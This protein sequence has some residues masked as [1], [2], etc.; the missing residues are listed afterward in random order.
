MKLKDFCSL[1]VSYEKLRQH[2]KKHRYLTLL[3]KVHVVKVLVFPVVMYRCK[4]WTIKK[5]ECWRIHAFKLWCWRRLLRVPWTARRSNQLILKEIY[6]EYSLEELMLKLKF[7]YFGYLMA[8]ADSLE[9]TLMLGKTEGRR[10]GWQR[11]RW[12]VPVI[13]WN[14]KLR[15]PLEVV[16]DRGVWCATVHG[17][18]KS[19]KQ[20]CNWARDLQNTIKWNNNTHCGSPRRRRYRGRDRGNI[21]TITEDFPNLLKEMNVRIQEGQWT[22]SKMNPETHTRHIIIRLSKDKIMRG[23]WK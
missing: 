20:F 6:P 17:E 15:K 19:Q 10:R 23:S 13:Q 4:S 2:I 16:E 11:M 5:A 3:T 8:R 7:Q 22:P 18:A 14:M 12:L 21:G 9:K 1:E